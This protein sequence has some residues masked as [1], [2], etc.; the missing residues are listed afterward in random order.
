VTLFLLVALHWL[1]FGPQPTIPIMVGG[2]L[3]IAGSLTI[4]FWRALAR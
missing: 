4:T 2:T 3:I 1:G